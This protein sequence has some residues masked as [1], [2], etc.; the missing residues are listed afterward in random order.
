MIGFP[1]TLNSKFDY[2]FVRENFPRDK[3]EP[4]FKALL[5]EKDAWY[6]TSELAAG[7][8]GTNDD[9]HKIVESTQDGETVRYQYELLPDPNSEMQ[10]I[11]Y[12]ED[13]LK[14]ILA[15]Q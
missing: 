14:A 13:E 1:K 6:C 2:E 15:K 10:K 9:T 5:A 11:G 4:K 3:W 8:T 12:T 7:E